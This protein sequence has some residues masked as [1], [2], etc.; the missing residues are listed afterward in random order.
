M[1]VVEQTA[2]CAS[3]SKFAAITLL[4][5]DRG[6][7]TLLTAPASIVIAQRASEDVDRPTWRPRGEVDVIRDQLGA[8]ERWNRARQVSEKAAQVTAR[9]R[10]G[11]LDVSR[12]MEVLRRQHE[13]LV[14]RTQEHLRDSARTLASTAPCRAVLVHRKQWFRDKVAEALRGSGVEVMTGLENGAEAVGFVIAE[15]PDLLLVEDSLS[16]MSGEDVLRSVLPYAPHTLCV[17]QVAHEDRVG[18][19]VEAGARAVWTRRAA[20]DDVA[21]ALRQL[22]GV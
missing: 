8:I 13:A 16:M 21:T 11:R 9:S 3:C 22:V 10:E 18:A 4:R 5:R 15:Q 19:L 7:V 17:A 12:R 20:P 1:L 6:D 14:A 2:V